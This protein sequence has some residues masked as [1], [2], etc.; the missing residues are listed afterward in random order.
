VNA[1]RLPPAWLFP[2]TTDAPPA[3]GSLELLVDTL[4]TQLTSGICEDDI[5][6]LAAR[7]RLGDG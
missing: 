7:Q 4:L 1:E 5:A 3:D 6:L 2:E